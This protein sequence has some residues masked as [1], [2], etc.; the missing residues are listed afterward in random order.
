MDAGPVA[1][2]ECR[3]PVSVGDTPDDADTRASLGLPTAMSVGL[4]GDLHSD[5]P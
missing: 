2:A 1:T 3:T 4:A 5:R